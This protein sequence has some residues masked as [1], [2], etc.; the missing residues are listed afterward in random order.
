MF[1]KY[2]IWDPVRVIDFNVALLSTL[3][4][5]EFALIF[6]FLLSKLWVYFSSVSCLLYSPSFLFSL[7]LW[8]LQIMNVSVMHFLSSTFYFPSRRPQDFQLFKCLESVFYLS[9]KQ[10]IKLMLKSISWCSLWMWYIA[11]SLQTPPTR[12]YLACS[13]SAS[14]N[15]AFPCNFKYLNFRRRYYPIESKLHVT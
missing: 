12:N 15:Y 2:L 7:I 11:E 14:T 8:G 1:V 10:Y 9:H 3:S 6:R 5:S 4:S 13:A